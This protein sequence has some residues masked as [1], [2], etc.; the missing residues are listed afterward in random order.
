VSLKKPNIV[1]IECDSMDGRA[2]GAMGLPPVKRATPALDA[3]AQNG[4]MFENMYSNNP[5]CCCSRASMLSGQYT[6]HC[7]GW[8]NYKGLPKSQPTFF[9]EFERAGYNMGIFGKTDYVSGNHTIRARVSAWLRTANL[10]LPEYNMGPPEILENQEKRVHK[11][12]WETLDRSLAW[13][14]ENHGTERPFFLYL[15][16]HL[17][18]PEFRTSRYYLD[19]VDQGSIAIPPKDTYRHPVMECQRIRKAWGHGLDPES[20]KKTRAIYYAMI[21]ETDSIVGSLIGA[22]REFGLEGDTYCIFTSDHGEMGMEHEQFYKSNM[23]EPAVRVPLLVTGPDAGKGLKINRLV[24]LIDIFPTLMSLAA[25]ETGADLDGHSLSP[26]LLGYGGGLPNRVFSE[27][28]DCSLNASTSM[29]REGDWKYIGFAGGY[30]PLL[31][32][33]K[34]DPWEINNLAPKLPGKAAEMKDVLYN[35]SNL[36]EVA[37]QVKEYDQDSFRVWRHE[38]REAG[39]YEKNMA[40]IYSGWD[41]LKSGEAVPWNEEHEKIV[42]AWLEETP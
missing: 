34:D 4:V 32:N 6:F 40:R 10:R 8:N 9:S 39:T 26:E 25:V 31:F 33:L 12:D 36:D 11:N 35:I 14:R 18:H 28:H 22:V 21:A 13:L 19:K 24:S 29:I 16:L 15:G 5:I 3:M 20:V 17:P 38:Q 41:Y 30:E 7:H 1:F 2:F 37:G 42:S 27:Y 23:Y